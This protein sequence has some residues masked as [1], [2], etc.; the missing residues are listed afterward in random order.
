MKEEDEGS[1]KSWFVPFTTTKAITFIILI[2]LSVYFNV[3]FNGFV[4]D[5][6]S[7]I[8]NYPQVH[9][10]DLI[11][12]FKPN[13]FNTGSQYRP[14][15]VVYFSTLYSLFNTQPFFYH[16]L[17][18]LIHIVNSVILFLILKHFFS[19]APSFLLSLVFLV[20]PINVESVAY[21]GAS[22]NPL[23]FLFGSVALL[24]SLKK[25]MDFRIVPLVSFFLLLALLTKETAILFALIILTYTY[26][27]KKKWLLMQFIATIGSIAAYALIRFGIGGIFFE[28]LEL[29]SVA[30]LTFIQ[31]LANIPAVVFYYLKT[32]LYPDKLSIGQ[33]WIIKEIT[34]ESFYLSIIIETI[35][36]F[37]LFYIVT[38]LYIKRR[39]GFKVFIFFL[40]WFLGGLI[41]HS[42][43]VAL[44][45]T[46]ADRWFYF[47]LAGLAGVTGII[48]ENFTPKKMKILTTIIL[49][50]VI[51]LLSIR[52]IER[53]PNWK[54]AITLYEHD[55]K[56]YQ[57]WDLENNLGA[58]YK[59]IG[60]QE[61]ALEHYLYSVDIF[62][63]ETNL[64][65]V[66]IVYGN[67]GNTIKAM[68]YFYKAYNAK[69]YARGHERSL[70][71]YQ[72]LV[73]TLLISK[74]PEKAEA[75]L[76]EAVADYPESSV[77]WVLVAITKQR[78]DKDTDASSAAKRALELQNDDL[79]GYIYKKIQDNSKIEII[80]EINS[81]KFL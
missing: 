58:E 59:Y 54:D 73:Q 69:S 65:N 27:F 71:T 30:R 78:L 3:F 67:L 36:L 74:E 70:T 25:K 48:L 75:I 1:I 31:R 23:F 41:L 43:I 24:T 18:I 57:T 46:V 22:G 42:Q 39:K 32:F 5:D 79:S 56:I 15:P 53:N 16:F 34:F 12:S 77:M 81:V 10:V 26:I 76:E 62:P 9:S 55:T 72:N 52:T 61:K 6:K 80:P 2:G 66:G 28:K 19:K 64:L 38:F 8:I 17:Q 13:L 45:W 44:D 29:T 11:N 51:G 4:W 50:L 68:E 47:T 33:D 40:V 60:N 20:H 7:Y 37:L 49:A 35:L 63:F 14:I 21:I